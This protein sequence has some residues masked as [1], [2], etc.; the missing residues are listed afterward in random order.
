M[1]TMEAAPQYLLPDDHLDYLGSVLGHQTWPV[2]LAIE[3]RHQHAAELASAHILAAEQLRGAGILCD[4]R[5]VDS[6]VTELLSVALSILANPE[7]VVEIRRFDA[8]G[9]ERMCLART[10]DRH[11]L[12]RRTGGAISVG[13]IPVSD[14]DELGAAVAKALG[15]ADAPPVPSFSAPAEELRIR[16]DRAV[17]AADYADVLHATGAGDHISAVYSAAFESCTGHTEIVAIESGPGRRTQSSG[18]VAVYDTAIG[19]ILAGPS[20]S[21]DGRIWTTLSAGT[22]HRIS[23][24][25]VLLMETLPS[26]RWMP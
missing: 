25:V 23:Q 17:T 22:P 19:R 16:L 18:A 12:A 8:S 7:T 15:S 6:G 11:V 1:W 4:D 10:G 21:P 24:A 9:C 5:F 14:D 20:T 3:P 2:V 13:E 26:G